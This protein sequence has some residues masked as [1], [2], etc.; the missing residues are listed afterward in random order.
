V[1]QMRLDWLLIKPAVN[2]GDGAV[3]FAPRH[4]RTLEHVNESAPGRISDHHPITVDL[5][6]YTTRRAGTRGAGGAFKPGVATLTHT[7]ARRPDPATPPAAPADSSR[8][9]PPE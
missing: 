9:A 6:L 3:A 8:P 2:G 4:G 1:G 5:P 7:A